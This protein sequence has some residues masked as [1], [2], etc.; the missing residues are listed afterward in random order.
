MRA[1]TGKKPQILYFI[2]KEH[3]AKGRKVKLSVKE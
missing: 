2:N 3:D 1:L